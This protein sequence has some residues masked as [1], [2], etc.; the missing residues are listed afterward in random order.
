MSDLLAGMSKGG[1]QA[2][3]Q[4]PNGV[5]DLPDGGM[6]V[7]L[8]PED[9]AQAGLQEEESFEPGGHYENLVYL[10]E[11]SLITEIGLDVVEACDADKES[12]EE[13]EQ[14]LADGV[15]SLG[16]NPN[17]P[18]S[19]K[20]PIEGGCTATHPL[21]LEAAVKFQSKITA[22]LL[23]AKGPVR[24]Q[25]IGADPEDLKEQQAQRVQQHMNYQVVHE[26]PEFAEE[27]DKMT[28]HLPL[29]GS[30]FKKTY[31]DPNLARPVSEFV[32]PDNF[33]VAETAKSL[34]SAER[35]THIIEKTR[36][37]VDFDVDAGLYRAPLPAIAGDGQ[38]DDIVVVAEDEAIGVS[39]THSFES[40]QVH[41]LYEQHVYMSLPDEVDFG[42]V[43]PYVVTVDADTGFVLSVRRNWSPKDDK[44]GMLQ[45]FSHYKYVPGFGF[46]GLGL[47]HLLGDMQKTLTTVLRSL[48]DAGQ[49]AN[50]QGGFKLKGTRL[51]KETEPFVMGQFKDVDST[52]QDISKS[53]Y[54]LPFKEPSGT[55]YQLLEYLTGA[56]QKFADSTE[57]V[58]Q[59]SSNYGPVGTT[60]ALLE[61]SVKFF[62]AVHKRA[63]RSQMK[64]LKI[65]ARINHE[66]LPVEYPY[67]VIGGSRTVL[68]ADYDPKVIDVIPASDPNITSQAHRI[69]IAQSKLQAALQDPKGMHDLREIYKD[70]YT[71]LGVDDIDSFLPPPPEAQPLDPMSDIMAAHQGQPIKAFPGQ[72]HDA[73]V[74]FKS[75]WLQDPTQGQNPMMQQIA[76][77]VAANVREHQ[78][79]SFQEKVQAGMQGQQGQQGQQG[80]T[81]AATDPKTM[82]MVMAQTAQQVADA[83]RMLSEEQAE[84]GPAG[85]L[86]KAEMMKAQADVM[87]ELREA[88][89]SK[90]EL[91]IKLMDALNSVEREKTRAKEQGRK[92]DLDE[93][94][95]EQDLFTELAELDVKENIEKAKIAS[96]QK[97]M[98]KNGKDKD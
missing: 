20:T 10:L 92:F 82:E 72:N 86:A 79:M 27:T 63:H 50:L 17:N 11:D 51:S 41:L 49:L 70:F 21:L 5:Q 44:K 26:M 48:V 95:L 89:E 61:A 73:H 29:Y 23:P 85:I 62:S 4:G 2:P 64:E 31:W 16:L 71:A 24:V 94:K 12:R 52:L 32:H 30:A 22:E 40:N 93:D 9:M 6:E 68:R 25:V 80:V 35:Y 28:F 3:A 13:W 8:S 83:N 33:I 55:L 7:Q 59:D 18:M 66:F 67:D 76:P 74:Q 39:E 88:E 69:S 60:M 43:L 38:T 14:I 37:Q 84:G 90:M 56:S 57:Q 96:G 36:T 78:L 19:D 42:G 34:E 75:A 47:F 1:P 53:L 46:H 58:I 65:L 45:W 98:F 81:G 77:Q 15:R 87:K 54:P 91:G 97:D